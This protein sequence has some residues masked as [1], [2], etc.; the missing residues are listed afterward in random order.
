MNTLKSA[1]FVRSAVGFD[2]NLD[3]IKKAKTLSKTREF[4]NADFI[5]SDA[6][7]SCPFIE[8]AFDNILLIDV[9]EHLENRTE[10]LKSLS[11]LLPCLLQK[12]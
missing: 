6:E 5:L 3:E 2:L 8:D 10:L 7:T 9:L 11:R 4:E 12:Q 1:R